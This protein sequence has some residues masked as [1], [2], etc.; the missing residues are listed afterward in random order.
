MQIKDYFAFNQSEKRGAV[1]LLSLISVMIL[2]QFIPGYLHS[3]QTTD[4]SEFEEQITAFEKERTNSESTAPKQVEYFSF[5]PNLISDSAWK[6]LGFKDWQI[7]NINKYKA[8]GGSWKIKKDVSRIYGLTEERYQELAPF[9]LLPEEMKSQSHSKADHPVSYFDFDPNTISNE[10]W[11]QLGFKSWQIENIN[12][13]KAKGGVWKIRSD[14]AKIYGLSPEH[15]SKLEPHILLPEKLTTT[16]TSHSKTRVNVN[17]NTADAA[18]FKQLNGI[19]SEKYAS[20]IVNYRNSLG[21]FV[22]KEQLLEVWNMEKETYEGFKEQLVLENAKPV[23]L[24]LNTLSAAELKEH[25]Y[26]SWNLANSIVNYREEHGPFKSV[27]DIQKIHLITD[28][29]YRK[30]VPYLKIE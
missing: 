25:P 30:I 1:V 16:E 17:I 5:N 22:R 18:T 21:G 12:K 10:E 2:A 24:N 28:E 20:I 6:A 26:I 27:T 13:Y 29:I 11:T 9:I 19:R 23:Q 8:N 7:R 15:Y 4:F 14:V 3:S